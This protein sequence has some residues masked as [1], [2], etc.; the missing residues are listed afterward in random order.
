[1]RKLIILLFVVMAAA[2][3]YKL[4]QRSADDK[5]CPNNSCP[6]DEI[7]TSPLPPQAQSDPPQAQ[8]DPPRDNSLSPKFPP[9]S[10]P[11]DIRSNS[12]KDIDIG[13]EPQAMFRQ[14]GH[15]PDSG[16]PT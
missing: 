6:V 12:I 4:H 5:K 11:K 8:S 16:L 9:E 7:P 3:A 15:S 13:I 10:M 1:M 14:S 2:V